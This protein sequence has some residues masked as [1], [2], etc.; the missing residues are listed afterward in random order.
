[1]IAGRLKRTQTP[2]FACHEAIYTFVYS[3]EGMALGLYKHLIKARPKRG[4]LCGR[5]VRKEM[6]K[7][8]VSIHDRPERINQRSEVGHLEGDLTFLKGNKSMKVGVVVDRKT[9]FSQLILNQS[10]QTTVVMKGLFNKLAA[11]LPESM[12]KSITFDNGLEFARHTLLKRCLGMDTYFCDQ[13]SPWHKGQVEQMNVMLHRYL[14]KKSVIKDVSAEQ[15]QRI[16]NKLN[17]LP[18]KCLGFKTPAEVFLRQ[19]LHF[20]CESTSQLSLG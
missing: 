11:T 17:N 1:M 7:D 2:F 6:I 10:K 13:S 16:Q 20:K 18:R 3:N 9:R 14:P 15:I 12:R 4:S 5:K 8:R 19:V